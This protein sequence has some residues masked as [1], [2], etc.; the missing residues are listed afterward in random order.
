MQR[1]AEAL[2]LSSLS[3]TL[4]IGL[5]PKSLFMA[6]G[7]RV[8][9][10]GVAPDESVFVEVFAHCGPMK[11]G[12]RHKI[13]SDALKLITLAQ[14]RPARLILAF[15]DDDAARSVTGKSWRTEALR[16]WGIEVVVVD[17]DPEMKNRIQ[18]VRQVMV[19]PAED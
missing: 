1:E 8:D 18:A 19:N 11:G 5:A 6:E 7:A 15:C 3:T 12:Q 10:D 16:T 13:D 14:S 17:L 9:V 4:G 2:I